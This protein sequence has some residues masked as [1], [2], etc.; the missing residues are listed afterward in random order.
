MIHHSR[1]G[2]SD[3][4]RG[5]GPMRWPQDSSHWEGRCEEGRD[6]FT[7]CKLLI[8][9]LKTELS[10]RLIL[11]SLVFKVHQCMGSVTCVNSYV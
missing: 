9:V 8:Q 4:E 3:R 1:V 6:K 11:T 7:R 2:L 5:A 10:I